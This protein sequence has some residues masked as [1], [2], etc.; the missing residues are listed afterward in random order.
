[1]I[2]DFRKN[3]D[4]PFHQQRFFPNVLQAALVDVDCGA[5]QVVHGDGHQ[6]DLGHDAHERPGPS[7]ALHGGRR[8]SH[9]HLE[10]GRWC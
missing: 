6:D 9:R 4:V 2:T 3:K 7:V 1:M 10:S 5:V 8:H